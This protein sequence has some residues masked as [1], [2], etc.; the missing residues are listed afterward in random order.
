MKTQFRDTSE[1]WHLI[2]GQSSS[3][4][5]VDCQ[6]ILLNNDDDDQFKCPLVGDTCTIV[7]SVEHKC[8]W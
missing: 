3:V 8:T 1:Q 6:A 7:E 4:A 2:F 5:I